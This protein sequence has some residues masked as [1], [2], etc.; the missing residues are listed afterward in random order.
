MSYLIQ[1][2]GGL[3]NA[4]TK[5]LLNKTNRHVICTTRN[6]DKS[7]NNLPELKEY[8]AQ[9][10][11]K[12]VKMDNTDENS[13]KD[14]ASKIKDSTLVGIINMSGM[15][16]A[17]KSLK[18]VQLDDML[19][20]FKVNTLAHLMTYKHFIPLL[21]K[22][23][24]SPLVSFS[25]KVGSITDNHTGGWFSYRSSKAALNQVIK[26]L[27]HEVT[28]KH[29]NST[30]F[31]YHPGTVDTNLI[32]DFRRSIKPETIIS[33]EVSV[34]GLW[35]LIENSQVGKNNGTFLNWKGETIPW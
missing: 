27:S 3:S 25:A 6:P 35:K 12:F 26:T 32:N 17:E 1:G 2:G 8:E 31:A 9:N 22:Q 30:C 5:L 20:A 16:F 13:I 11:L 34:N 29:L 18:Q 7:R 33:P 10:R 23:T 24:C 28:N 4:L 14:V 21:D 19:L 15:L